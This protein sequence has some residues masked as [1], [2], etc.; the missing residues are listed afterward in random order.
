MN[1]IR[2]ISIRTRIMV[3]V[4]LA[5][6]V[7][8]TALIVTL[9]YSQHHDFFKLITPSLGLKAL[10]IFIIFE[11]GAAFISEALLVRPLKQ[12]V[13]LAN[14]MAENDLSAEIR[15]TQQG[16]AGQM[17]QSLQK[18]RDNLKHLIATIQSSSERVTLSSE[19]LNRIIEQA[20]GQ[21]HEINEGVKHLLNVF[22]QNAE[23]MKQTAVAISEITNHSQTTAELANQI[24]ERAQ[25][26]MN[27]AEGGKQ[28]VDSIVEAINELAANTQHVSGEVLALEEQSQKITEVVRIIQQISE[29]THLLA[30]NAAIEAARAGEEG[31]GFAVVAGQIRKLAEDTNQS[32]QEIGNLVQNMTVRT[33]SVVAAV[34]QTGEKVREGVTQSENVKTNIEHIIDNMENTFAM[35][36]EISGGV[37]TQAASLEEMTATLEDVNGTIES[38]L[39]VSGKIQGQLGTQEKIFGEIEK[40]SGK[41]VELS[42][43]M[44]GLTN[45]FKL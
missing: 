29:Q 23:S 19:E 41:L 4:F 7:S 1:R 10:I 26:V 40:T 45:V 25:L 15:T 42:E 20:N 6:F 31:R 11:V 27:S 28:S 12:G 43:N 9:S 37:N 39:Q 32:L 3:L 35:L 16:E 38:G 8:N 5:M 18:A 44:N 36:T 24:A 30:L 33:G 21:V 34:A 22:T 2:N 13:K 17:I 14:S